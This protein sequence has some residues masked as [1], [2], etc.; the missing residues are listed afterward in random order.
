MTATLP[1]P[2]AMP[3]TRELNA[4]EASPILDR[5]LRRWLDPDDYTFARTTCRDLGAIVLN[6]LDDLAALSDRYPPELITHDKRGERIDAVRFHPAR[7]RLAEIAYQRFGMAAMSHRSDVLGHPDL[8]PEVAKQA[9]FF[10]YA[11]AER[12]V[13][14][15]LSMT[16]VLARVLRLHG[17]QTPAAGPVLAALT[18]TDPSVWEAAMFL[19]EKVGGSDVGANEVTAVRDGEDWI[20]HGDKWF[21][22]NC[23]ADVILTLAR[24]DADIPG[25]AGLALF[26][27]PRSWDG[28]T[29]NDYT[30]NRLKDKLG[31]RGLA[32]GEVTFHGTRAHLIGGPGIGFRYMTEM[33]NQTR[34]ANAV[35]AAALV[36]RSFL[37]AREHARGRAAFGRRLV[38]HPLMG[39]VLS[40]LTLEAEACTRIALHAAAQLQH[41]DAGDPQAAILLRALTPMVKYHTARRCQWATHEAMEVRGGNGYIADWPDGLAVRDAQLLSIWEGSGNIMLL[42]AGRVL[43][44]PETVALLIHELLRRPAQL[45]SPTLEPLRETLTEEIT[46]W[47]EEAAAL[48]AARPDAAQLVLRG[49]VERY[50][51]LLAVGLLAED[52][53]E[54]LQQGDGRLALLAARYLRTRVINGSSDRPVTQF[55]HSLLTVTEELICGDPIDPVHAQEALS[56]LATRIGAPT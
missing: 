48:T 28:A 25:T 50:V 32:S 33:L 17:A 36:H 27:V 22:S 49:L 40:E 20:L 1:P 34:V 52:A 21:C 43:R 18:A 16:D 24:A 30:I 3:D 42:D 41:A 56:Q 37:E 2:R 4:F 10:L 15:G 12:S 47:S 31:T 39:E 7:D 14:T 44:D 29:R 38:D 35:V 5:V 53:D 13:T 11:H 51:H 23:Q 54:D 6:E 19:T 8:V 9:L 46:I 45:N 55:D 26:L